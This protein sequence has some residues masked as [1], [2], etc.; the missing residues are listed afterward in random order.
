M[1]RIDKFLNDLY[2]DSRLNSTEVED[3]KE[4][5]RTHLLDRIKEAKENGISENQA[6]SEALQHFGRESEIFEDFIEVPKKKIWSK[7]FIISMILISS[8]ILLICSVWGI[9]RFN[10]QERQAFYK[11]ISGALYM[12]EHPSLDLIKNEVN[13]AI[14]EGVIKDVVITTGTNS[15]SPVLYKTIGTEGFSQVDSFLIE[16]QEDSIPAILPNRE[17]TYLVVYSY[18][19]IR[20]DPILQLSIILLIGFLLTFTF[21]I[22]R[23]GSYQKKSNKLFH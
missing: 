16:T 6:V 14:E 4:E 10:Q 5:M 12:F 9:E 19:V 20:F 23:R 17:E 15:S 13:R 22:V 21:W 3:M 18:N 2:R 8:S 11:G 1:K 7:W